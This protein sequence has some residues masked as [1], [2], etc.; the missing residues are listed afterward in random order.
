MYHLFECRDVQL[1][2]PLAREELLLNGTDG[3]LPVLMI[4]R[5]PKAV[6][7][8]KNQNPWKECNP[9]VI[10]DRGL[11]LARRVSGGGTVYHDPGNVNFSWVVDR[12][13]YRPDLLHG[14]LRDALARFGL[15]AETAP[16]GATLVQ[17]HKVSGAAYCYRQER[18][19]H[20]G[21]MLW[22]ADLPTLRAALSAPR[23]RL[24]THAVNSVPARVK[25]LSE[26]LPDVEVEEVIEALVNEAETLFGT[27]ELWEGGAEG[28]AETETRFRSAEWI[29]GQTPR[30]EVCLDAEDVRMEMVI[31][32][33]RVE[34][35]QVGEREWVFP[36]PPWF[37]SGVEK[38]LAEVS[39]VGAGKISAALETE[40]WSRCFRS[41]NTLQPFVSRRIL[42]P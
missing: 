35:V 19:L 28:L 34:K 4:W 26:L 5:G 8:G 11:L 39:G 32:K 37:G 18:V 24:K 42:I 33:G 36:E 29:W 12:K 7:L 27:A 17:G 38:S 15:A 40:G 22:G 13:S 20:H 14:V 30:F 16:S 21:T 41:M 2:E 23:V 10:Q 3:R 6:V 1:F 31:R 9:E 25:N